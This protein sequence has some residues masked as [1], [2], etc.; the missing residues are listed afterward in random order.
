[1]I[2]CLSPE[3]H[4]RATPLAVSEVDWMLLETTFR[5]RQTEERFFCSTLIV[6]CVATS[7]V[8]A[9]LVPLADE[10][11]SVVCRYG[12]SRPDPDAGWL[13]TTGAHDGSIDFGVV[14]AANS[15]AFPAEA[16]DGLLARMKDGGVRHVVLVCPDIALREALRNADSFIVGSV[17]TDMTTAGVVADILHNVVQ[18]PASLNCFDFEDLC[19]PI[20]TASRPAIVAEA[21]YK[22]SSGEIGFVGPE[23]AAAFDDASRVAVLP[24][25]GRYRMWQLIELMNVVRAGL[26]S[27][28][29]ELVYSAP[30]Y[31]FHASW[32]STRVVLVRF[33]CM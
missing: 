27:R 15:E 6:S 25:L 20:G 5:S 10:W 26:E 21:L 33:L 23:D 2:D 8:G 24:T 4:A 7:P 3:I 12:R 11:R 31:G 19:P 32:N 22:W 9:C 30:W 17:E 14:Y 28:G 16:V 29:A 1:M 18:A 13:E